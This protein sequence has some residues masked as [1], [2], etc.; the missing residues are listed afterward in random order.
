M[1]ANLEMRLSSTTQ[2]PI[3]T[4]HLRM[5]TIL[6]RLSI[7]LSESWRTWVSR[8]PS[9]PKTSTMTKASGSW[10][11]RASAKE[12]RHG[13]AGATRWLYPFATIRKSDR[14]AGFSTEPMSPDLGSRA[15]HKHDSGYRFRT[16]YRREEGGRHR[17][18]LTRL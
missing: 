9:P 13:G 8:Q 7:G 17:H 10:K 11:I 12:A 14:Q 18:R 6:R 5:R 1:T 3:K 4:T 16:V 15:R 2:D